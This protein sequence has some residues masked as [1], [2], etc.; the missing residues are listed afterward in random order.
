MC[1]LLTDQGTWEKRIAGRITSEGK[2]TTETESFH[3]TE[4]QMLMNGNEGSICDSEG[5]ANIVTE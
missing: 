1:W 3:I 5:Y 4:R 2:W